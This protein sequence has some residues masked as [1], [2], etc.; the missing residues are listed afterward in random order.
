MHEE[1]KPIYTALVCDIMDSLGH[2]NQAMSHD[3]RPSHADGWIAGYA[4]TLDAYENHQHHDD[5]Y[6]KIFAA[7]D[8][9]KAGDVFVAATNGE[10]KSGLWGELLSTAAKARNV[11]SV[12]TDGLVRVIRQMNDMGFNCFCKGYSP[13]DSAG[14]IIVESV[15]ENIQCGGVIVN[16]GDFILGDYDGV[17]VI[18]A[19]I[20]DEVFKLSMEKLEG[21]NTVRDALAAGRSPREVFDE[22]GIL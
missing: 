8:L 11:E 17:A 14:R 12:V 5:P 13:L 10:T 4:V 3:V 2:R 15:N 9:V 1:W 16:P 20:K 7:Y 19:A 22:Y 18:P 6:G 21:E